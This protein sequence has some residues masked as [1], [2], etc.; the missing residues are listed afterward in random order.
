MYYRCP[1]CGMLVDLENG[2]HECGV[3]KKSK[4]KDRN[5][6]NYETRGGRFVKH[7]DKNRVRGGDNNPENLIKLDVNREKAWH[8]VF[9]NRTMIEAAKLLV[10]LTNM[11]RN[12]NYKLVEGG[13]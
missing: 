3:S 4:K 9:G 2:Y 7:H 1:S 11:K 6:I 8:L 13:V 10:R 12:T 5:K